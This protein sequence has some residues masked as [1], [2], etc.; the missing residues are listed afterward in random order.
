MR[1]LGR[2]GV[3]T[4]DTL[5]VNATIWTGDARQPW[6]Q[7]MAVANGRI[8]SLGNA[9]EVQ[10]GACSAIFASS[11]LLRFFCAQKCES[12]LH[13]LVKRLT[14]SEFS[15]RL[16]RLQQLVP[17]QRLWTWRANL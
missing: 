15:S 13:V 8:L 7:S 10:V 4:A 14:K 17:I 9:S 3:E 2:R 6:A 1:G 11:I 16:D 5:F 12:H